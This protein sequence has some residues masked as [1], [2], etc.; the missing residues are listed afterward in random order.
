MEYYKAIDVWSR[1]DE[2]RI[3]RYRCFELLPDSGYSVQSADYYSAPFLDARSGHLEKQLLELFL[4]EAPKARSP[5]FPTLIEAIHAFNL[6]FKEA[7]AE[8]P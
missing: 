7:D 3:V 1:R 4:E 2:D 6:D 8:Q 5:L